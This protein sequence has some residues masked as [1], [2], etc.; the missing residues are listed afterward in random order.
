[1]NKIKELFNGDWY[2][3]TFYGLLLLAMTTLPLTN[4]LMLPIALLMFLLWLIKWDWKEKWQ[5]IRRR[6][7]L[8]AMICFTAIFLMLIPGLFLSCNKTEAFSAFDCSLWLLSAPILLLTTSPQ[9]FTNRHF[10][11]ALGLFSLGIGLHIVIILI[12]A[13]RKFIATGNTHYFY[14]SSLSRLIHPSYV[15]MY[16]TLAFFFLMQMISQFGKN[17][18]AIKRAGI[19]ALAALLFTAVILLQSKAGLICFF[20]LL[21]IWII[22]YF[23]KKR[24][25]L[26][27]IIILSVLIGGSIIIY[28][29]GWIQKNR[30]MESVEQVRN[31]KEDPY[32]TDSSEMR[33]TL[34]K[35]TSELIRQNMPW[36]V[37]TGDADQE[38]RLH[39]LKKNYSNIIGHR[40]NAHCQYLQNL[41]E[42]GIPGLIAL[43]AFSIYPLYYSIRKRDLLYFSFSIIVILNIA[44]ECMLKVRSGV[45]FIALFNALFFIN[46]A[47]LGNEI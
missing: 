39:A 27:G 15:A 18:T 20:L 2:F 43:L 5:N 36:G 40:Y 24:R 31:H 28:K 9:K 3:N 46:A 25:I 41:L 7:A 47:K 11:S 44:V 22:Y 1:M 12:M 4:W 35:T 6:R 19:I 29:S 37:G 38:I 32:G 23:I 33:L 34:W 45:D 8:P 17:M 16:A 10:N 14:Y 30:L 21:F 13:G 26:P 42:T